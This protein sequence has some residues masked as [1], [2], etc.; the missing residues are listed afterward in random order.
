MPFS[1]VLLDSLTTAF[2]VSVSRIRIL[3][4]RRFLKEEDGS[5]IETGTSLCSPLP[6]VCTSSPGT[7]Y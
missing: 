4:K 7:S 3:D 1:V 6:V 5:E 2:F